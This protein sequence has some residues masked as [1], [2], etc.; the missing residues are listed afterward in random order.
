[1]FA[2]PDL[3]GF[4]ARWDV[5][6]APRYHVTDGINRPALQVDIT[7][8]DIFNKVYRAHMQAFHQY[9]LDADAKIA[10]FSIWQSIEDEASIS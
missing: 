2:T 1:M 7:I 8:E 9:T 10:F 3:M 4:W 5:H 6:F